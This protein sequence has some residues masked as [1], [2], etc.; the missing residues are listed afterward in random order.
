MPFA[1]DFVQS[2]QGAL[3]EPHHQLDVAKDRL[4]RLPVN[5]ISRCA[6]QRFQAAH[7]RLHRRG[8]Y[9][10]RSRLCKT[11]TPVRMSALNGNHHLKDQA[12]HAWYR[13]K[14]QFEHHL[15]QWQREF[16]HPG[17]AAATPA[18]AALRQAKQ[19]N[20]ILERELRRKDKALAHAAAPLMWQRSA[21]RGGR[22]RKNDQPRSAPRHHQLDHPGLPVRFTAAARL[23]ANWHDVSNPAAL[24]APLLA[25]AAQR[26]CAD[27]LPPPRCQ[28]HQ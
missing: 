26:S 23:Q 6:C 18:D 13:E 17:K 12:L 22:R 4:Q 19:Q 16:C 24:V 5:G 28:G 25:T 11:L 1:S 27:Q 3:P 10:Q 9:L 21:R 20:E 8:I 7:H 2:T 14:G 15:R